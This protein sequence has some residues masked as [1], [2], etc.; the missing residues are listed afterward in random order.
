MAK[1]TL[2]LSN[3]DQLL[4][5]SMDER[6]RKDYVVFA[7]LKDGL[8][9][10]EEPFPAYLASLLGRLKGT[11]L[12][13]GANTGLYALLAAAADP[14]ISIHA[15][16]PVKEI[17]EAF[18][19]NADLNPMLKERL[20]LHRVALTDFTGEA[21]FHE[22]MNP[23]FMT[24]TSG[25]N[26][27]FSKAHGETRHYLVPTQTLDGFMSESS[28]D[29]LSF[30]K[31][32]VE[33]HEKEVMV[34]AETTILTHRPFIGIELLWDADYDYFEKFLLNNGYVDAILQPGSFRQTY[35][36]E[37]IRDGWNHIFIPEERLSLAA[38]CA[39]ACDL[40]I[41]AD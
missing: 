37:F 1:I 8:A 27:E 33:G 40:R 4:T 12:D 15:F 35:F 36:P 17:A 22:T 6:D 10:Y 34:G 21:L 29:N 28:I 7:A 26:A 31:I 16:E 32:D 24:T 13:I 5:F 20:T 25:L 23:Y 38:E 41:L 30:I 2:S 3:A 18:L 19:L 39:R 11:F 9:F 14:A